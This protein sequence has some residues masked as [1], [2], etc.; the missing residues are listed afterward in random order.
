MTGQR[1]CAA[2]GGEPSTI[3]PGP[4]EL[5]FSLSARDRR[6]LDVA[7]RAEQAGWDAVWSTESQDRS[8]FV[9]LAAVAAVTTRV[10]LGT[11]V[12]Y[13]FARQPLLLAAEAA[14]VDDL[15]GGRMRVGLGS[16]DPDRMRDWFATSPVR[17]AARMA[18][19]IEL[20]RVLW[21]ANDSGVDYAGNFYRLRVPVGSRPVGASRAVPL[22]VGAFGPRMAFT[23]GL[24]ADGVI[25]HPLTTRRY[26]DEVLLPSVERGAHVEGRT[27]K[28]AVI[29]M[30]ITSI[31]DDRTAARARAALQIAVYSL[32]IRFTAVF[33]LHGWA[34][35]VARIRQCG[36]MGD[37]R[38]AVDVVT[39]D[40]LSELALAGTASEVA[41]A[42]RSVGRRWD[43]MIFHAPSSVLQFGSNVSQSPECYWDD[44]A[45]ILETLTPA[46]TARRTGRAG[47][48]S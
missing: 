20:L 2:A 47:S 44:V 33:A 10:R 23:A 3:S 1:G 21:T 16:G 14:H 15:S 48:R 41:D 8:A 36:R 42:W 4:R 38:A 30:L 40:M 39:D 5:G 31:D 13:G 22:Y 7:Q 46:S 27:R 29:G 11:A 35:E 28:P 43:S 12:A 34:D 9:T 17:P 6:V 25:C 24:A 37:W 18:E 45:A 19:L 32:P 26:L